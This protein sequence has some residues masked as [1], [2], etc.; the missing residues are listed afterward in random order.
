MG[1]F[2]AKQGIQVIDERYGKSHERSA[3]KSA[4]TLADSSG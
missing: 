1:R 3:G 4:G 2:E